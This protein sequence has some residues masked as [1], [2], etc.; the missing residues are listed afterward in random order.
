MKVTLERNKVTKTINTG[1]SIA[2]L[3]LGPWLPMLKGQF[4]KSF[5]HSLLFVF[6]LTIHYWIQAFGGWNKSNLQSLLD[7]DWKPLNNNDINIVNNI[8]K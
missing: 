5:K 6:T 2:Y 8:I 7:Q 4:G 3:V 1:V